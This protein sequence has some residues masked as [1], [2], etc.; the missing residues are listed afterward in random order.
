M[1]HRPNPIDSIMADTR[2]GHRRA[3]RQQ[4][5]EPSTLSA[6]R[7]LGTGYHFSPSANKN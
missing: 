5:S 1:P 7:M 2:G 6:S 4:R 3:G